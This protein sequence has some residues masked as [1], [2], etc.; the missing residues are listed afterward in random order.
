MRSVLPNGLYSARKSAPRSARF[1][2]QGRNVEIAHLCPCRWRKLWSFRD[3]RIGTQVRN[4]R[5]RTCAPL[6]ASRLLSGWPRVA[7]RSRRGSP[8]PGLDVEEPEQL[9]L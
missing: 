9:V 1:G 6:F 4:F 7:L 8:G 5:L 3:F 2:A